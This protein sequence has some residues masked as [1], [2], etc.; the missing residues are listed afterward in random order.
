MRE[1]GMSM[2][3]GGHRP[4]HPSTA[5]WGSA[6]KGKGLLPAVVL[7]RSLGGCSQHAQLR[8]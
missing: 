4:P 5:A 3:M 8:A 6:Y 1:H 2:Q 7:R